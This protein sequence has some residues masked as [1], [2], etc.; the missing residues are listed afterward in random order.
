VASWVTW[1]D[2]RLV[3]PAEPGRAMALL[4]VV[5]GMT[6]LE[7]ATQGNTPAAW[8]FLLDLL[9]AAQPPDAA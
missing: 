8:A 6:I 7:A 9:E 3:E 2:S 5:E 4:A 1:I